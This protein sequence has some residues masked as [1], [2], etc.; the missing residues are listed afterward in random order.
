MNVVK[1]KKNKSKSLRSIRRAQGFCLIVELLILQVGL[2]R[3]SYAQFQYGI[4]VY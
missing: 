2:L 4:R 3:M 1:E